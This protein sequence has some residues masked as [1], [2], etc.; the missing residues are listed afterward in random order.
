MDAMDWVHYRS[1]SIS[2]QNG[3]LCVDDLTI[4]VQRS[5]PLKLP[6]KDTQEDHFRR[7]KVKQKEPKGSLPQNSKFDPLFYRY[8][9]STFVTFCTWSMSPTREGW[10]KSLLF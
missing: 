10:S 4:K 2:T 8:F 6:I 7:I 9:G 1:P 5:V 3:I